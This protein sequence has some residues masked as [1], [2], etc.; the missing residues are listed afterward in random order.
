MITRSYKALTSRPVLVLAALL[1]GLMLYAA[2]GTVFAQDATIE[3][4]EDRDD[5]VAT[6][7]ASDQEDDDIE[8]DVGGVDGDLFEISEDGVLTFMAQP[9]FENPKDGDEDTDTQGDQGAGDNNY[10]V[11][12]MAAKGSK[13]VTVTVTN[14]D[15]GWVSE[16][17]PASA[18]G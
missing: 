7:Q 15:E 10:Q 16:P 4:A 3:Y 6:F 14:A 13:D 8:W 1:V 18:S 5:P 11:T 9:D 17:E 2:S 12:V